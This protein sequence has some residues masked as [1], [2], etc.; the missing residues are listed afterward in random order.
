MAEKPD[1]RVL[2]YTQAYNA[3]KT[4]GMAMDS[5]LC[6]TYPNFVYYV[7]DNGS[8]DGTGDIIRAYMEQDSRVRIMHN[9]VN[10]LN[11]FI[12]ISTLLG[13]LD[14]QYD[15]FAMLDADDEYLPDFLERALSFA[16]E[17]DLDIVCCGNDFIDAVTGKRNGVRA[18]AENRI[19]DAG[20]FHNDFPTCYQFGATIWAHLFSLDVVRSLDFDA[21]GKENL[22]NGSDTVF[23][24]TA[25]QN[26]DK[27]G[28]LSGL[29]LRYYQYPQSVISTFNPVRF[30]SNLYVMQTIFN[31]LINKCDSISERNEINAFRIYLS[32]INITISTLIRADLPTIEAMHY[33][34]E[35]ISHDMTIR[36]INICST[37]K[38]NPMNEVFYPAAKW[39]LSHTECRESEGAE[40]AAR[41]LS[42]M[43]ADIGK[44]VS[45]ER[46][47]FVVMHMPNLIES[48]LNK[49]YKQIQ[50]ALDKWQKDKKIDEPALTEMEINIYLFLGKPADELFLFMAEIFENKPRSAKQLNLE[51]RIIQMISRYTLLQEIGVPLAVQMRQ[52]VRWVIKG[53]LAK[54]EEELLFASDNVDIA[55]EDV[56]SYITLAQSLA[57]AAEDSDIFIFFEKLWISYLLDVERAEEAAAEL[58]EYQALMPGDEDFAEMRSRLEALMK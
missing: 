24:L 38:D 5:I 12:N 40:L 44:L 41:I 53:D 36:L 17:K 13:S 8:V 37:G 50:N 28:I 15:Y 39:M 25:Y 6:Q 42:I 3:E 22:T 23:T 51:R 19:L 9:E 55:D 43:Y 29:V 45:A 58:D 52:A 35:I 7:M 27:I 47:G 1:A 32:V 33:L 48:M 26:T 10:L 57:A 31:L 21:L 14:A 4:L 54:A 30:H 56:E 2:V 34:E 16:A 46:L 11:Y 20:D 49:D 18:I